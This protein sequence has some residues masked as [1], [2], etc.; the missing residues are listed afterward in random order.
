MDCI[1]KSIS[2]ECGCTTCGYGEKKSMIGFLEANAVFN[3]YKHKEGYLIT[4]GCDHYFRV[5]LTKEELIKLAQELIDF[6]NKE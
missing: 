4:E 5:H 1:C 2:E 3:I 6:A